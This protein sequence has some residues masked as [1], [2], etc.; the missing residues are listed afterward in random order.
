MKLRYLSRILSYDDITNPETNEIKK[1]VRSKRR[2]SRNIA[3]LIT[4]ELYYKN[5][6]FNKLP[7]DIPDKDGIALSNFHMINQMIEIACEDVVVHGKKYK[8]KL[9]KK[10]ELIFKHILRGSDNNEL[11]CEE[12]LDDVIFKLRNRGIDVR[13]NDNPRAH[14]IINLSHKAD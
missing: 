5:V 13:Y 11:F 12:V 7:D 2:I 9:I 8:P 1:I 4:C 6:N 10:Y 3:K 14:L